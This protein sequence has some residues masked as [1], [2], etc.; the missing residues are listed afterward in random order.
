MKRPV[1]VIGLGN[2]LMSDEGVGVH[3]AQRFSDLS[4]EYSSVEFIDAGTGGVS[5]LHFLEGRQKAVFIDCAIMGEPPGVIRRFTPEQVESRKALT[6]RSLH[7]ADLLKT[8]DMAKQ[9]GQCPAE[10]TIFGIEPENVGPGTELSGMLNEKLGC[11]ISVISK[12]L[13]S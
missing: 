3:L 7:E 13:P 12:E 6:G 9:L 11:Y 5:I 8:I 2:L 1:V 10:I 4:R